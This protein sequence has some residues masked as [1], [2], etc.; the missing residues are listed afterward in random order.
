MITQCSNCQAQFKARSDLTGKE[1]TCP[2]CK[3]PF[4]VA[5]FAAK[6]KPVPT[7]PAAEKAEAEGL[8]DTIYVY[9][10]ACALAVGMFALVLGQRSMRERDM[11]FRMF[12]GA[13]IV[14]GAVL[15]I[16]STVMRFV[17]YYKMWA[18]IQDG[19][20]RTSPAKAVGLLLVPVFNIFWAIYMFVGF[21]ADFDSF[22]GRHSLRT[23]RLSKG[24]LIQY[25][26][27]WIFLDISFVVLYVLP[28]FGI[29]RHLFG[30]VYASLGYAG[31]FRY[32]VMAWKMS[33]IVCTVWLLTIYVILSTR[34]CRAINAI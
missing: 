26:L 14:I 11:E 15:A 33:N 1:I 8:S 9:S 2:R 22:A 10:V 20:A 17:L 12:G 28:S 34:I 29:G 19:H 7:K 18:A 21:G 32:V 24:L 30:G 5:Q 27:L 23:D 16:Y 3:K 4:T 13:L 31:G 25:A 6:P